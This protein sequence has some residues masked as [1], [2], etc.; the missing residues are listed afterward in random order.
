MQSTID[1]LENLIAKAGDVTET[2]IELFKLKIA[3][4]I[5]ETVS[6]LISL[7]AIVVFTV[8]AITIVSMGVAYWIGQQMGKISYGFFIVGGF[9]AVVGLLMYRFRKTWI[10][11]PISNLIIDKLVK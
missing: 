9:Y 1:H 11:R 5:S 6:S 3:G 8:G 4:K 2:K 10:K 7:M